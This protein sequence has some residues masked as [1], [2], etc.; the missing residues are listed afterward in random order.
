M[1]NTD[2]GATAHQFSQ[3]YDHALVNVH[4]TTMGP[5]VL[6]PENSTMDPEQICHLPL[7]LLPPAT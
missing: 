1:A 4:H 3:A 5:Q 2:A 7:S 6:L